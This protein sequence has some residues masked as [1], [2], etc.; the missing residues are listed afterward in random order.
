[1]PPPVQVPGSF[2]SSGDKPLQQRWWRDFGDSRLDRLVSEALQANLD[3]KATWERLRQAR[4]I[5]ERESSGL[6]PEVSAVAQAELR[7][8]DFGESQY[9]QLGLAAEYEIDLWGRI[10]SRADAERYRARASLADYQ[11]AK[12]SLSAEVA[13]TWYRATEAR[14]QV[15]LLEEQVRPTPRSC[16][17]S[18]RGSAAARSVRW[19]SCARSGCSSPLVS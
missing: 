16:A 5:V 14:G 15:E 9:L 18:R 12:L 6:I 2:S 7:Q 3:L 19:T 8:P 1:V 11:T 4:A 13:R 10:R 17:C